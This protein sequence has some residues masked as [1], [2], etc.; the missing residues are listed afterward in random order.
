MPTLAVRLATN[1]DDASAIATI[2]NEAYRVGEKGIL[3]DT[4]EVPLERAT[5]EEV[6]DM[7][8]KKKLSLLLSSSPTAATDESQN[9][10]MD[11]NNSDS[12]STIIGCVKTEIPVNDDEPNVGEWGCL[13]L[14][15]EHQSKGYAKQLVRAAEKRIWEHGC[16]VCQLEL[17]APTNWKHQHK[18]RLRQWYTRLGYDLQHSNDYDASTMRLP[19][20][21]VLGDRFVLATD[22]DFTCYRKARGMD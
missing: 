18:E 2:L 15:K 7:V 16:T 5:V 6:E 17:L 12:A 14:A 3:V 1:Q 20:G 13:A 19:E 22:G 21:S 10:S 4:A 9:D 11:R 8:A